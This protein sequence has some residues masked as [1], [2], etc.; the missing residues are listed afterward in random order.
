MSQEPKEVS[1]TPSD[2]SDV[3]LSF[4]DEDKVKTEPTEE[5]RPHDSVRAAHEGSIG[6]NFF[7]QSEDWKATVIG[8]TPG[9]AKV[10]VNKRE[11]GTGYRI[12]FHEGGTLP[13]EL[14][15]WFTTYDKAEQAAR[16]YLNR[17][18]EEENA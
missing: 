17:K 12:S 1:E 10:Q 5:Q 3:D 14:S 11:D 16:G 4:M 15:G 9:G 7:D 18:W 13:A 2:T 8:E 6:T